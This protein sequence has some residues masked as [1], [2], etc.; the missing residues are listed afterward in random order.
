MSLGVVLGRE[1]M[2]SRTFMIITTGHGDPLTA[3]HA[4]AAHHCSSA[5]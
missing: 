4:V 3:P 1:Q 5:N 2:A